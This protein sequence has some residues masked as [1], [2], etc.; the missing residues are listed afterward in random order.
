[1]FVGHNVFVVFIYLF[2]HFNRL[3]SIF[4]ELK[5]VHYVQTL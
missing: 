5:A 1:M 2:V 4:A 3:R